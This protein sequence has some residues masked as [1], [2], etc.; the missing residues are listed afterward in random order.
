MTTFNKR[1]KEGL[2]CQDRV[3]LNGPIWPSNYFV[4]FSVLKLR[5]IYLP[6]LH[7]FQT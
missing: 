4:D 3:L 7:E 2:V 1:V 6:V 5:K